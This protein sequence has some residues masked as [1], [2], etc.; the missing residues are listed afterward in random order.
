MD[1]RAGLDVLGKR[2]NLL[3]LSGF[4]PPTVDYA[5]PAPRWNCYAVNTV[6]TNC[7]YIYIYIYCLFIVLQVI[8]SAPTQIFAGRF[9]LI[10][11]NELE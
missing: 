5:T 7:V 9:G 2:K 1:P 11:G 8:F 6:I 4:E 10:S 3:L